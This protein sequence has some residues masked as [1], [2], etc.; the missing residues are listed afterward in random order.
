MLADRMVAPSFATPQLTVFTSTVYPDIARVWNACIQSALPRDE[1]RVEVFLD[2]SENRLEDHSLP[3]A[4]VLRRTGRRR[5]FHDAYNDALLRAETP[6]LAFVD[7]DIF[8]LSRTVWQRAL[9]ELGRP[10]VAAVSCFSRQHCA[11]PGTFA[12]I[13]KTDVYRSVLANLPGGFDPAIEGIAPGIQPERWRRFDT[14]DR[15]A[16]A[17]VKAGYEICFLNPEAEVAFVRFDGLTLTRKA[18]DWIGPANFL[19]VVGGSWGHWNGLAGNAVLKRLHD[20]LFP[21]GTPFDFPFSMGDALRKSFRASPRACA[22][23]LRR[24]ARLA[25]GARRIRKA[26]A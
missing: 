8:W 1:I 17:V 4:V 12:V 5:D 20:Y 11:S 23:R 22:S 14:G 16:Q 10:R 2:S 6:Y 19:E 13:M 18:L 25:A 7:T 15:A 21:G 24:L 3:G 9:T 26:L